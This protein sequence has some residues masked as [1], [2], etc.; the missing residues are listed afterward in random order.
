[1]N[2]GFL[3]DLPIAGRESALAPISYAS[4]TA[5]QRTTMP[6]YF[7]EASAREAQAIARVNWNAATQLPCVVNGSNCTV[8]P[9]NDNSVTHVNVSTS[10]DFS[11]KPFLLDTIPSAFVGAGAPLAKSRVEPVIEWITGSFTPLGNNNFRVSLDRNYGLGAI[12]CLVV[13]VDSAPGIRY[14]NQPLTITLTPNTTGSDQT[15]TF[16]K[17]SDITIT[18][19]APIPAIP[20]VATSNSGLP[21]GGYFVD[22]GPATVENGNVLTFTKIPPQTKFPI[23]VRIAAWQW[24]TNTAPLYKTTVVYQTFNIMSDNT[25]EIVKPKDHKISFSPNPVKDILTITTPSEWN[26][27]GSI[28]IYDGCGSKIRNLE[29]TKASMQI[30]MKDLKSG[31]YLITLSN[32]KEII[33]K[34]IV[35]EYTMI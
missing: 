4:A 16:N 8:F 1:M 17:V 2:S 9:W 23:V 30:D 3:A 11:L 35:K 7:D 32:G 33:S 15:I 34:K 28:S 24:G 6:W 21:I 25:T 5:T 14:S 20:L 29:I 27:K 31:I 19:N 26:I 10:S 22:Y 18:N 13:R 12:N